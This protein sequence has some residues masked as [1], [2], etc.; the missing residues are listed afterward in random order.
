MAVNE[1]R[2][3]T[4]PAKAGRARNRGP[5]VRLRDAGISLKYHFLTQHHLL[6]ALF[7]NGPM[8]VVDNYRRYSWMRVLLRNGGKMLDMMTRTRTGR[9]REANAILSTVMAGGFV[10]MLEGQYH[11]RDRLVLHEDMLPP[12]IFRAMDLEPWMA[13]MLAIMLPIM[14]PGAMEAFIDVSEN[15]GIPPDI[16]SLPKG[17]MGMVLE[18]QLP[19]VNA[20]VTSNLPCD[21][22]MSSYTLIEKQLKVPTCRVDIPFDFRSERAIRY[23]IGELRRM[24]AWLEAHTPGRMDWDRLRNIIEERNRMLALEQEL[25]DM[26]RISPAPMAAEPVYLSHLWGFNMS[27]GTPEATDLFRQVAG[28]CRRNVE[29]GIG[30]L[31]EERYRVLL[32]NP[33]MAHFGEFFVWAEQAYGVSLI[34]DSMSFNRQP[35]IDTSTE[36]S[37]L[38]GLAYNIMDGPMARHTRGPCSNFMDD[39]FHICR[40]FSIDMIWVAGHIGCKNTQAL[41]GMLRELCRQANI[42]LL[43]INYDL[44]DPR[45]V[46]HD[47]I[48]EQ[49]NHFMETVMKAERLAP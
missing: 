42:P 33:P 9:Y 11:R 45:I 26:M 36:E 41:N 10:R 7:R 24:I 2:D 38:R 6:G 47:G 18:N 49:V 29:E 16:C 28:L 39:I 25:W 48:K 8:F 13:E 19:P 37:M 34:M 32:W 3:A 5:A 14:E 21:G 4:P 46:T 43:I 40:V 35:P 1:S 27:P 17:T 20:L 22:G 44:M 30:A 12:E 23:F 15:N 31:P